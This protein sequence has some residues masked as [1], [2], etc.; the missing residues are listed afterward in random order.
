MI[1]G[2]EEGK[3]YVYLGKSQGNWVP[4]M[5]RY[6]L[7]KKPHQCKSGNGSSAC[8]ERDHRYHWG[9]LE[10]FHEVDP[11]KVDW[12]KIIGGRQNDAE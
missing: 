12:S 8:F 5:G 1:K 9:S 11:E 3:H 7:D 2:F 4:A 6:M 10:D